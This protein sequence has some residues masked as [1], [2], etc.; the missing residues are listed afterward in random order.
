MSGETVANLAY[1]GFIAALGGALIWLCREPKPT[2]AERGGL[3]VWDFTAEAWV[4]L[5]A[6]ASPGPGQ[7]T[8]REIDEADQLE[9]LWLAPAYGDEGDLDVDTGLRRLRAAMGDEQEGESP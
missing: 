6:G 4:D 8:C 9:L 2:E 3:T 5:P 1:A 7:M